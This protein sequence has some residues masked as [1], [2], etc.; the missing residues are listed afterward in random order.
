MPV[1][2]LGKCGGYDSDITVGMLWAA[3]VLTPAEL[4]A[5]KLPANPTPARVL[6]MSLGGSQA[7]SQAYIDAIGRVNAAG[8]V[9]VA[10]AGNSG[11]NAVGSPASCPGALGV[12]ALRHV[13]DKVGFSDLGPE[14]TIAAPG[15][16][17][18]N[19]GGGAMPLSDHD[20]EQLRDDRAGRRRCGRDL[21]RQLQHDASAP[22]SR[23]R[24]SRAR[25]R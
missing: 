8:A 20:D 23:R 10:A 7:C 13:G 11:G 18:V 24:S 9:V 4:S 15:G 21:H 16:N 1:R 2:V 6:N 12:T 22:A 5:M 25:W 3:G 17:C 14:I 19:T